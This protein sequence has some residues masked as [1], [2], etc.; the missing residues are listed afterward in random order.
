MHR[1][2]GG[3]HG[4]FMPRIPAVTNEARP[5]ASQPM[6]EA[7]GKLDRVSNLLRTVGNSPA[8]L[9]GH[10]TGVRSAL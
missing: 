1:P 10:G 9:A 3:S 5:R 6:P 8:A 4:R 7:W 2:P